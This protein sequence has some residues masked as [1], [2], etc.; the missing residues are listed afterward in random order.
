MYSIYVNIIILFYINMMKNIIRI[1]TF[2]IHLL[3]IL[4][5]IFTYIYILS[6][7][8]IN[9]NNY[10]KNNNLY[11]IIKNKIKLNIIFFI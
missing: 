11:I 9:N 1:L 2:N 10:I 8:H 6:G 3:I 4:L 7:K 5:H